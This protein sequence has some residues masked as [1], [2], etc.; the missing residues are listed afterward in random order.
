MEVHLEI[1]QKSAIEPAHLDRWMSLFTSTVD[2]LFE[3]P[4]ATRAKQ[5][6]QSIAT[7]MGIKITQQNPIKS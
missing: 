2:L 4:R 1:S 3:G 7:M 5:R 6:A